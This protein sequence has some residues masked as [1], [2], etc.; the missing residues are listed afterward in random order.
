[1]TAVGY[2]QQSK[3]KTRYY[4][5]RVR[6]KIQTNDLTNKLKILF[7]FI[8]VGLLF[9]SCTDEIIYDCTINNT[10]KYKIDKIEFSCAIDEKIVSVS[11]NSVS[12][13]FQLT[14]IKSGG[15]FFSE[16]LVCV[17]ITE[18]SDS[19]KTYQNLIGRTIS[20]SDMSVNTEFIIEY[21]Q[22]TLYP[23]DIFKV[24]IK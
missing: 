12:D 13:K 10:T 14:Y 4:K 3:N 22:S 21:E 6:Q 24:S 19:T 17:T 18:Y 20:I 11:P 1:M 15:R 8:C 23:T 7:V 5:M 16:P 9:F 2:I